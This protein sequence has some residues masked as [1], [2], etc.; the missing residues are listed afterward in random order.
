MTK[1]TNQF[2]R[3]LKSEIEYSLGL[4][5]VQVLFHK[6]S[7]CGW[8]DRIYSVFCF[9]IW[10]ACKGTRIQ[11]QRTFIE[12][13]FWGFLLIVVQIR[14]NLFEPWEILTQEWEFSLFMDMILISTP[15]L[16]C[17]QQVATHI[18]I[19]VQFWCFFGSNLMVQILLRLLAKCTHD[20]PLHL[21]TENFAVSFVMKYC[22]ILITFR[23]RASIQNL[24]HLSFCDNFSIRSPYFCNRRYMC[25]DHAWHEWGT[26]LSSHNGLHR[27]IVKGFVFFAYLCDCSVK[28]ELIYWNNCAK[29]S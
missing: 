23:N 15:Y 19:R 4:A 5:S 1:K 8:I 10:S 7:Y 29:K 11:F 17:K 21:I 24:L 22:P 12:L 28:T 25:L 6:Y 13:L 26:R 27:S 2:L 18:P 14:D 20:R 3:H 9:G 16:P